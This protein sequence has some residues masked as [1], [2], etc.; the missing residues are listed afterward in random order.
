MKQSTHKCYVGLDIAKDFIDVAILPSQQHVRVPN[1][2]QGF[3]ELIGQ[4]PRTVERIVM[5][6][7]GKYG[8]AILKTLQAKHYCVCAINPRRIRRFA[9][10][11][12]LLA[13]TDQLDAFV[14]AQ[15]ARLVDTKPTASVDPHRERLADLATT[16][17]QL[18]G[19]IVRYKNRTEGADNTLK[20]VYAS[21][22]H[23]LEQQLI[24]VNTLIKNLIAEHPAWQALVKHLLLVKGIG[25]VTAH[26]LLA[27]LPELGQV[28]AGAIAALVGVAPFNQDSGYYRGQRKITGGRKS[29]RDGMYMAT[30]VATRHHPTIKAFY[31]RLLSKGKAKK[32]A[33]IACQRKLLVI[34][35]AKVRDFQCLHTQ[36]AT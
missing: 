21:I 11:M 18:V 23:A 6:P 24:H 10:A 27:K 19:D 26:L 36:Q 3:R 14:C 12:G 4:L 25:E 8:R 34:L 20:L 9:Q 5:E 1:N 29:V 28:S 22:I 31:Q 32:L 2:P 7:T 15:F 30:L 16:R 17:E 33:L 35:N 13:K